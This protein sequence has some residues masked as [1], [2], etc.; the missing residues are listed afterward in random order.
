MER[1]YKHDACEEGC[2]PQ[3]KIR[4]VDGSERII[5]ATR[6]VTDGE[7]TVFHCHGV[8]DRIVHRMS[9]GEIASGRRRIVEPSGTAR[10]IAERSVST[11]AQERS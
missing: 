10:W 3:F 9:A 8:P 2:V 1:T 4:H 7:H 11:L 6:M 5:T